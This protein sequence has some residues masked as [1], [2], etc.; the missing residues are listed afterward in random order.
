MVRGIGALLAALFLWWGWATSAQAAPRYYPLATHVDLEDAVVFLSMP[1]SGALFSIAWIPEGLNVDGGEVAAKAVRHVSREGLHPYDMRLN[2]A[3]KGKAQ[4]VLLVPFDPVPSWAMVVEDVGKSPE[5]LRQVAIRPP[6]WEEEWDLFFAPEPFLP[7]STNS[8]WSPTL[9]GRPWLHW[10]WGLLGVTALI[11]R[12]WRAVP[13]SMALLAG[14]LLVMGAGD[15][16]A[17][18]DRARYDEW[19]K[20]NI[21]LSANGFMVHLGEEYRRRIGGGSWSHGP[22]PDILLNGLRYVLAESRY[23][24]PNVPERPEF[25]LEWNGREINLVPLGR[26]E[27]PVSPVLSSG[28]GR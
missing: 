27:A 23:I 12:R 10:Q 7:A 25:R 15:L 2:P 16:R 8:L 22:L 18:W 19:A 14:L 9:L 13:W 3:W 6:S 21:N 20:G 11:L 26:N 17:A 1:V 4:V 28:G 5:R 24:P